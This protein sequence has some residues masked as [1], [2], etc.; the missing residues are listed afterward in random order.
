MPMSYLQSLEFLSRL[1]R[2]GIKLGLDTITALL[3]GLGHPER[4]FRSVHVGG[5][6]GKGST[7]AIAAAILQ[8]AGY[9]VGLY[10]SPHLVELRER[11]RIDG[12]MIAED[13]VAALTEE[14]RRAAGPSLEPTF[15]E[16]TTAMAFRHF[17]DSGVEV[18]VV[19]VGLGGRFDATNILTPLAAGITT[20]ALDHQEY[21]GETLDAIA[22]DVGDR[23]DWPR[24]PRVP[25]GPAHRRPARRGPPPGH[26]VRG[27]QSAGPR[28]RGHATRRAR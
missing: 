23:G 5:T 4:R 8:A 11:I 9:R 10:T 22:F 6:N 12:A 18:A 26:A 24:C 16:Y 28:A 21:L 15:F 19:E 13:R 14:V 17:A 25:A 7:A 3:D 27:L 1:H 20:V 2:H